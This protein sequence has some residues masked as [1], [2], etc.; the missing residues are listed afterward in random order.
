MSML[1][2]VP[3]LRGALVRLEPLAMSHAAD[4][5]AAA[6]ED[7]GTYRFTHVPRAGAVGG[8]HHRPFRP[9]REQ[10]A[11]APDPDPGG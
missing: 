8:L 2:E 3:V 6:E 9:R 1:P 5:A 11:G 4:L 10:P 7:R